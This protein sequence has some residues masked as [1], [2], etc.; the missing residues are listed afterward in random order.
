MQQTRPPI[1]VYFGQITKVNGTADGD[2]TQM[3]FDGQAFASWNPHDRISFAA[4]KAENMQ[5]G[6][7]NKSPVVGDDVQVWFAT[8]AQTGTN[9]TRMY[10]MNVQVNWTDC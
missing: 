2:C 7:S 5:C 1:C 10:L 8:N 9:K 4:L 3:T 6:V